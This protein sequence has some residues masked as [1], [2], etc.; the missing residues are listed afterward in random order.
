MRQADRELSRQRGALTHENE[1]G[2]HHAGGQGGGV[3][4]PGRVREG[5][6]VYPAAVRHMSDRSGK[7][8]G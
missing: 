5:G 2:L 6:G 3:G 8:A 7:V 1:P 4:G